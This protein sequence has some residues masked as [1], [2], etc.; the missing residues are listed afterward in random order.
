MAALSETD[1]ARI[2]TL[3]G[4]DTP[5]RG[6]KIDLEQGLAIMSHLGAF[7]GLIE[8]TRDNPLYRDG[9]RETFFS[10]STTKKPEGIITYKV[11]VLD[12]STQPLKCVFLWT[13][14]SRNHFSYQDFRLGFFSPNAWQEAIE[15]SE[16]N[17]QFKEPDQK[18]KQGDSWREQLTGLRHMLAKVWASDWYVVPRS[19]DILPVV[20]IDPRH[21]TSELVFTHRSDAAEGE[22]LV[23]DHQNG[24][25]AQAIQAF[26]IVFKQ[27]LQKA[28]SASQ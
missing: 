8:F 12:G 3:L 2:G 16:Y 21:S 10:K 5:P 9:P 24:P 17:T 1:I 26:T 20:A 22:L 25:E 4:P 23:S 27:N 11:G 19:G 13:L 6:V 7:P 14:F 15:D 28:L 18:I